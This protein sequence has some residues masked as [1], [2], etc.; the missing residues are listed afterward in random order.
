MKYKRIT[1]TY[2]E[3]ESGTFGEPVFRIN[4]PI[5]NGVPAHVALESCFL[6][7]GHASGTNEA[8]IKIGIKNSTVNNA[9]VTADGHY[10]QDNCL[11]RIAFDHKATSDNFYTM[12]TQ[13][14]SMA[15][16]TEEA[17][18]LLELPNQT[19]KLGQIALK[20]TQGDSDTVIVTTGTAARDNYA[21]TLGIYYDAEGYK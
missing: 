1:L 6:A 12:N 21:I 17:T 10:I 20:I 5:P 14:E 13:Y 19:F 16:L 9:I 18:N 3:R 15:R 8:Y 7:A 11:G 4:C 2:D